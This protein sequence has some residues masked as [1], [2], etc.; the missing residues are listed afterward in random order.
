M[1]KPP[2]IVHR[3]L[4]KALV[5]YKVV[6]E[7]IRRRRDDRRALMS[8]QWCAVATPDGQRK[9]TRGAIRVK[10]FGLCAL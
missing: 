2:K 4:Y 9:T 6:E 8:P 7:W 5:E 3:V 1:N 10:G